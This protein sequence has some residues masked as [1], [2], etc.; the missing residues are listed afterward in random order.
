MTPLRS[1][2]VYLFPLFVAVRGGSHFKMAAT[3]RS[4]STMAPEFGARFEFVFLR[5]VAGVFA[6][7]QLIIM[8]I[9]CLLVGVA[10][11]HFLKYT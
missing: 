4:R 6:G 2:I 8:Q 7:A 9:Y 5:V 10:R 1:A 3:Q 11:G